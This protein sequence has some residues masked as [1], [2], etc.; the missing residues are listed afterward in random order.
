MLRDEHEVV[1]SKNYSSLGAGYHA[2]TD[3]INVV[4][5]DGEDVTDWYNFSTDKSNNKIFIAP[6]VI[7]ITTGSSQKTYDGKALENHTWSV[8]GALSA[9]HRIVITFTGQITNPG[10][11]DNTY[12]SIKVYNAE[13]NVDVTDCYTIIVKLGTLT[14]LP[15]NTTN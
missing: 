13:G 6:K 5:V 2:V 7:T 3:V 15:P 10:K 8:E 9:G 1:L 4:D 14:V 12:S 11:C